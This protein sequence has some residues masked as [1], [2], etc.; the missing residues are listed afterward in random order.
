MF[1]EEL[2]DVPELTAALY[3]PRGSTALLDAV[4]QSVGAL[5]DRP[6]DR[7][8]VITFTDGHENASREWTKEKVSRLIRER[9]ALGNWTFAFF[10]AEID[11]WGEAGDMGYGAGNAKSHARSATY[12]MMKAT[13]RVAAIMSKKG[14]KRS[15]Y[16]ADAVQ[17]AAARPDVPDEEIERGLEGDPGADN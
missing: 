5:A 14:M 10:G 6:G 4:G 13:G 2:K 16:Y 17:S 3:Q 9:E 1:T 15:D 12:D 8:I 11:A 7:F